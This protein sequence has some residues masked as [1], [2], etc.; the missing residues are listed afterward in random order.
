MAASCAPPLAIS[1]R[2]TGST[3][4]EPLGQ[5][6]KEAAGIV[7]SLRALIGG[8]GSWNLGELGEEDKYTV[9]EVIWELGFPEEAWLNRPS[10]APKA[11]HRF[12]LVCIELVCPEGSGRG[13]TAGLGPEGHQLWL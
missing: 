10:L 6:E 7:T 1:A 2:V 11:N 4:Q 5:P 3:L 8:R 12:S 13:E 9:V